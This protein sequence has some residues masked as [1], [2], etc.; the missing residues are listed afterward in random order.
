MFENGKC[1]KKDVEQGMGAL[2]LWEVGQDAI[3]KW[4]SAL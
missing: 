2:A 4:L 1:Y 3:L